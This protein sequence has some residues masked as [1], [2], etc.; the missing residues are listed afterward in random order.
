MESQ[1]RKD[2]ATDGRVGKSWTNAAKENTDLF[3]SGDQP[4]G[5]DFKRE[6]DTKKCEY[7]KSVV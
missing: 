2:A 3:I 1:G 6:E 7:L 4:L 5:Y